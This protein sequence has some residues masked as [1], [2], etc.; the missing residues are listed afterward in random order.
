MISDVEFCDDIGVLKSE[1]RIDRLH[2]LMLN[3]AV[4][5]ETDR[6]NLS[7]TIKFGW[8]SMDSATEFHNSKRIVTKTIA[9]SD[10]D[11]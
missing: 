10:L 3:I 5:E 6:T 1:L 2:E 11:I 4:N 7:S 9:T 8:N